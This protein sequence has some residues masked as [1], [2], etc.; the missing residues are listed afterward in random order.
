MSLMVS[1]EVIAK[2]TTNR[3]CLVQVGKTGLAV[4]I[5]HFP[6]LLKDS[7]EYINTGNSDLL[8]SKRIILQLG[9]GRLGCPEHAPYNAIHVGAAAPV[10]PEAVRAKH[11]LDLPNSNC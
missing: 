7:I 1:V 4:G 10:L 11:W 5:E 9:D 2:W 8:K 6:E 3:Y